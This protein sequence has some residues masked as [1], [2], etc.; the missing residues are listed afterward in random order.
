MSDWDLCFKFP[1]HMTNEWLK[2]SLDLPE[3]AETLLEIDAVS[4]NEATAA[5][6]ANIQQDGLVVWKR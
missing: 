5:L 2:F 1:A 3:K 6:R 4:W